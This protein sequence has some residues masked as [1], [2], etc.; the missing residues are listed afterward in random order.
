MKVSKL[1]FI[2]F[3]FYFLNFVVGAEPLVVFEQNRD[4]QS[5]NVLEN[6]AFIFGN[7]SFYRKGTFNLLDPNRPKIG[8][9]NDC[10][11]D[12]PNNPKG[13]IVLRGKVTSKFSNKS[14]NGAVVAVYMGMEHA[15]NK[16]FN[17]IK[18]NRFAMGDGGRLTN[19]YSYDITENGEFEV[20]ACNDYKKLTS[21]RSEELGTFCPDGYDKDS[22]GKCAYFDYVRNYPKFYLTVIC[23]M[24]RAQDKSAT[25]VLSGPN[26]G[27]ESKILELKPWIGEILSIDNYNEPYFLRTLLP[28]NPEKDKL[29]ELSYRPDFLVQDNLDLRVSCGDT[30]QPFAVPMFL[31]YTETDNPSSCRMD[32][33]SP[34]LINYMTNVQTN[35]L[36]QPNAGIAG[37]PSYQRGDNPSVAVI[38]TLP[39]FTSTLESCSSEDIYC[40]KNFI[41]NAFPKPERGKNIFSFNDKTFLEGSESLSLANTSLRF[42]K[43]TY[44]TPKFLLSRKIDFENNTPPADNDY[45]PKTTDSSE[46]QTDSKLDVRSSLSDVKFDLNILKDLYACFTTF[47][48]PSGKSS[49]NLDELLYADNFTKPNSYVYTEN[50]RIPSCKELYCATEFVPDPALCTLRVSDYRFGISPDAPGIFPDTLRG[51]GILLSA[52]TG[53]GPAVT[54]SMRSQDEISADLMGLAKGLIGS[55]FNPKKPVLDVKYKPVTKISDIVACYDDLGN[56]T[57]LSEDGS[58]TYSTIKGEKRFYSPVPFMSFLS[59]PYFSTFIHSISN[60]NYKNRPLEGVGGFNE[61][62]QNGDLDSNPDQQFAHC[63]SAVIPGGVYSIAA[64]NIIADMC[65]RNVQLPTYDAGSFDYVSYGSNVNEMSIPTGFVNTNSKAVDLAVTKIGTPTSLCLCDPYDIKNC[66]DQ[67]RLNNYLEKSGV[68]YM[69]GLTKNFAAGSFVGSGGD[70]FRD[71][72]GTNINAIGSM[73]VKEKKATTT[74]FQLDSRNCIESFANQKRTVT[75]TPNFEPNDNLKVKW[76]FSYVEL[77]KARD[78]LEYKKFL[79]Y[80][81][82]PESSVPMSSGFLGTLRSGNPRFT[83]FAIKK[84]ATETSGV[85]GALDTDLNRTCD[86]WLAKWKIKVETTRPCRPGEP[87]PPNRDSCYDTEELDKE[88]DCTLLVIPEKLSSCKSVNDSNINDAKDKLITFSC[89]NFQVFNWDNP[90]EENVS[91]VGRE[92]EGYQNTISSIKNTFDAKVDTHVIPYLKQEY[93]N[94]PSLFSG[95]ELDMAYEG[96]LKLIQE[97][98]DGTTGYVYTTYGYANEKYDPIPQILD[99]FRKYSVWGVVPSGSS[100]YCRT[101][102]IASLA[103][104][105]TYEMNDIAGYNSGGMNI[106]ASDSMGISCNSMI[107]EELSRCDDGSDLIEADKEININGMDY[108]KKVACKFRKCLNLCTQLY[109]DYYF[110]DRLSGEGAEPQFYCANKYPKTQNFQMEL[111]P[112]DEGCVVDYVAKMKE[113]YQLPSQP[114]IRPNSFVNRKQSY[115]VYNNQICINPK[116]YVGAFDPELAE[117]KQIDNKSC[118]VYIQDSEA[119]LRN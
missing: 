15:E 103:S 91:S 35:L 82:N 75:G 34:D 68:E 6:D 52:T 28:D 89:K 30:I 45:L 24:A 7:N 36:T 63:S 81:T 64:L 57:N 104:F 22:S 115:P 66:N 54:M 48:Q 8:E 26:P 107:A 76:P 119:F 111:N 93:F 65:T 70:N 56:I 69:K 60:D 39:P 51:E 20:Y 32:D 118:P 61:A 38:N 1:L 9:E 58:I 21:N 17:T 86:L 29:T 55:D 83:V 99:K 27:L 50:L 88:Q 46:G 59:V 43:L 40:P 16:T 79:H 80:T 71:A 109:P 116:N 84:D 78:E 67:S 97:S 62:C 101:P 10:Y 25:E 42:N 110:Y 53:F 85:T 106:N 105:Q 100:L 37:T 31:N 73:C 112:G 4:M 117:T 108:D 13:N 77:N 33:V 74:G 113:M 98:K 95:P 90:R 102:K 41:E 47:N 94:N 19:F 114:N 3:I 5:L 72:S 12:D 96:N 49:A 92:G 23:G 44:D 14:I 2:F 18:D 87:L 11:P